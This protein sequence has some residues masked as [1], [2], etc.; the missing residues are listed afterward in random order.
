M[1]IN[2]KNNKNKMSK[3]FIRKIT[4]D[5]ESL[6][7]K[8][9]FK[10]IGL[11]LANHPYLFSFQR[12][13]FALGFALG[14]GLGVIPLPIQFIFSG[15][16]CYFLGAS[17]SGA[18]LA[19]ILTNPFTFPL[20]LTMAFYIGKLIHAGDK[21]TNIEMPD[22]NLLLDSPMLWFKEMY[23]NFDS[24]GT[25]LLTGLPLTGLILGL[26]SYALIRFGWY[27]LVV[28]KW[29]SRHGRFFNF[30]LKKES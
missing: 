14:I 9:G 11:F 19:T 3:K 22:V 21:I 12:R 23:D 2:E 10:K 8:R 16:C 18:F 15:I 5:A 13:K 4:I 6:Q 24:V 28:F 30:F 26:T 7:K 25:L 20:I 1:N 27:W 29:H 17:I